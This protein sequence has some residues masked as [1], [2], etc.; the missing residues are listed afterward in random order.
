MSTKKIIVTGKVQGVFFRKTAKQQADNMG[1]LGSAQN[2]P[3]GTV[4][5]YAYGDAEPL[6]RFIE[7]CKQGSPGAQVAQV[8]VTDVPETEEYRWFEILG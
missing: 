5:I 8:M 7:W 1:I 2:L 6:Q 4:L 3:D